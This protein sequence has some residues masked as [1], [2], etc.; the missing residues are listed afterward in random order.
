MASELIQQRLARAARQVHAPR[1][2]IGLVAGTQILTGEGAVP[3]EFLQPKARIISRAHG[4]VLLKDIVAT[5]EHL[6]M[7][8]LAPGTLGADEQEHATIMPAAQ[9]VLL[10][11][12]R[13]KAFSE[14]TQ[15]VA[16][17][18]CL[19]NDVD[20]VDL[21]QRHVRIFKLVFDRPE[22]IYAD[23]IEVAIMSEVAPAAK[24]A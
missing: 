17:V 13:A 20:I 15:T 21:G 6:H 2:M 5:T 14:A 22:V 11:G 1:T 10:R 24:A 18:G 9:P 7:I 16:P 3:V 4:I 23:G 8:Q 19:V 12:P